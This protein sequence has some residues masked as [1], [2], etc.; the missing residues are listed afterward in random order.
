MSERARWISR[1][2]AAVVFL[3][4]VRIA[5]VLIKYLFAAEFTLSAGAI[6][7]EVLFLIIGVGVCSFFLWL[8]VQ[9][10][11]QFE[12]AHIRLLAAIPALW[13]FYAIGVG[14]DY[15]CREYVE[16]YWP[17]IDISTH[18]TGVGMFVSLLVAGIVYLGAKRLLFRLLEL[19]EL[20][21]PLS[22]KKSRLKYFG[23]LAFFFWGML[24]SLSRLPLELDC[25][26]IHQSWW[27]PFAVLLIPLVIARIFYKLCIRFFVT[28]PLKRFQPE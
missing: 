27:F 14:G 13:V 1:S 6:F 10:W 4:S 2:L 20:V 18:L 5:Y 12:P 19:T 9:F 26:R 25:R 16:L 7:F 8:A 24:L 17:D 28:R 22:F 21:K 11:T 15:Y 23:V 3:I